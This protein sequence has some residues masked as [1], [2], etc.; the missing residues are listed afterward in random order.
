[1]EQKETTGVPMIDFARLQELIPNNG[2]LTLVFKR[3]GEKIAFCYLPKYNVKDS[4]KEKFSPFTHTALPNELNELFKDGGIKQIAEKEKSLEEAINAKLAD[5]QKKINDAKKKP[6]TTT[7]AQKGKTVQKPS[8]DKQ[9][10]DTP[11]EEKKDDLF[12]FG[13]EATEKK[14]EKSAESCQVTAAA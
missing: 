8:D 6:A 9:S 5:I 7:S 12:S 4:E 10:T 11:K 13:S 14:D 2:S 1:M 3:A